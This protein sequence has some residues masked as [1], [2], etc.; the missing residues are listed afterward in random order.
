M[1]RILRSPLAIL[2]LALLIGRQTVRTLFSSAAPPTSRPTANWSPSA[3]WATSGSSRPS[4]ASPGR[5]HARGARHQPGL[6]PRRPIDRLLAPTATAATTSSSSPSRAAG[7]PGSPSTRP[8]TSS[9]A[10]RPTASTSCSRRTRGID[11]PPSYELYTVPVE[12]GQVAAITAAEGREAS[13]PRRAT[14]SP[15]SAGRAP[16]IA[17]A[18]AARPTT[19][20]GSAT[21]TAPTTASHHIQRPGQLADVVRRRQVALL[22]QRAVTARRPTSSACPV[23]DGPASR[24]SSPSRSP[25]TRTTASAGPASAA[26]AQWIVYECGADLWVVS[27]PGRHAAASWPSRS[28][29]TTRPTPS[30]VETF[31]RG[32]PNSPCRADEKHIAFVVHGEL[33]LMPSAPAARRRG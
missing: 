25:S 23:T 11:F 14:R 16:G 4:A 3:T 15:T 27:T 9:P 5:H 28:T 29:P 18:I 31:T 24:R 13:S 21:P 22:R 10:G 19:T 7:P 17:R 6:Q 32:T 26:T 8:T 2:V 12:G 30:S 20:S 1:L 33:F